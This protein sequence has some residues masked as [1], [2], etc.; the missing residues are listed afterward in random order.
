[1]PSK[2][3]NVKEGGWDSKREKQRGR[4]LEL[5]QRA[6]E[7]SELH[8]QVRFTLIPAQYAEGKC[9]FRSVVYVADFT[10]KL[11]DGTFVVEDCKGYR[12]DTYRIKKK[13]LYERYGYIINET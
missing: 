8:R 12:T 5:L 7:I 13:L 3:H 6:G 9:L 10:Y 2:Y 11:K 1:M 4:E